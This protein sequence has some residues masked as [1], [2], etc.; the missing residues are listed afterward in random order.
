MTSKQFGARLTILREQKKISIPRLAALAGIDYM[1]IHRYETG[2]TQ[3]TLESAVRIATGLGVTLDELTGG[4][5]PP[6]PE[7]I[8]NERLLQRMRD[9]DQLPRDRQE[10]AMRVLDTVISGYE[11]ESL[12]AKL[13]RG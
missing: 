12:S 3:P 8:R 10:M 4:T 7:P 13:K 9:L 5:P 6:A 1:Q 2:K 11:L